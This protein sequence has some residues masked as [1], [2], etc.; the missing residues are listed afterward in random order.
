[1]TPLGCGRR[2]AAFLQVVAMIIYRPDAAGIRQR[3]HGGRT[4]VFSR[5]M[6]EMMPGMALEEV[7]F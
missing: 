7:W 6:V 4:G 1:M 3:T 5:R 2:V